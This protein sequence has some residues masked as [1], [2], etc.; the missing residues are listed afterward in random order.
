[1]LNDGEAMGIENPLDLGGG[2]LAIAGLQGGERLAFSL[3]QRFA[4]KVESF[5]DPLHLDQQRLGLDS[6]YRR[7]VLP[8]EKPWMQDR[9][10]NQ[11]DR[12]G[13]S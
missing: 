8:A 3:R 6:C 9:C 5:L 10:S 11:K 4:E 2:F 12:A 7:I 1:M 13:F